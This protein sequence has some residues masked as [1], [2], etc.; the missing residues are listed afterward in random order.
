MGGIVARAV[1]EDPNRFSDNVTKLLMIAPPNHGS[2]LAE[3]ST[4]S[5]R[6]T[7]FDKQTIPEETV[8]AVDQL[9][10]KFF[11]L[12]KA[13]LCPNSKFLRSLN[14]LSRNPKVEYAIFCG[15]GGPLPGEALSLSFFVGGLLLQDDAQQRKAF[16]EI[17]QLAMLPEWIRGSGDGVVSVDSARLPGVSR[18]ETFAFGHNDFGATCSIEADAAVKQ[19]VELLN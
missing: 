14:Q 16:E 17:R 5:L 3:L 1:V 10:E 15:T 9:I 2:A 7:L 18:F 13:D 8:Q 12:A 6:Q 11:G 19:L 4:Q